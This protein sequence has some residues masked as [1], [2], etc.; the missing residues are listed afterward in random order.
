MAGEA[1]ERGIGST[2]TVESLAQQLSNF[3]DLIKGSLVVNRRRCGN[4]RCRCARGELHESLAIT[5]KEEGRSVLVHVPK[6]LETTARQAIEHYHVLKRLVGAISRMNVEKFREKARK[7]REQ[8][9][10]R[11]GKST[12]K[13]TKARTI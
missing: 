4:P 9:R 8:R 6:H 11:G 2:G 5:Y 10:S 1:D 13:A 12:G 3:E 7:D